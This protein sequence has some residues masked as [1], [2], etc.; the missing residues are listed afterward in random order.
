MNIWIDMMTA[1]DSYGKVAAY[2]PEVHWNIDEHD[3][4]SPDAMNEICERVQSELEQG[5]R[6]VKID[7][8]METRGLIH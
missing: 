4:V 1:H 5:L 2:W 8:E 7:R 6:A 3:T